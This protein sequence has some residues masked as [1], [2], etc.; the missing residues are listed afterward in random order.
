MLWAI[1]LAK[2]SKHLHLFD[3]HSLNKRFIGVMYILIIASTV[4]K[5]LESYFIVGVAVYDFG[6]VSMTGLL[7][8]LVNA[9]TSNK[10]AAHGDLGLNYDV[11]HPY[12][13]Y[14]QL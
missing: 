14:Q 1:A 7:I 8:L 2:F 11:I 3:P 13:A 10:R 12:M 5:F 9:V 4:F 6:Y